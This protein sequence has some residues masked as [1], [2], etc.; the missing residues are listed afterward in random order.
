MTG[1]GLDMTQF[2]D[3]VGAH[4]V[5][6]QWWGHQVGWRSYRDEWLSEGFAEFTSGLVLE[7]RKGSAALNSFYELKRKRILEK[8]RGGRLTSDQA[9]PIIQGLRL[10]TL[11]TPG[12]YSVVV[13]DK[14]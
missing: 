12:A 11:Q 4:E 8:Q 6:H 5:A 2:V 7:M 1:F 10:S 3:Q 13:Y 9:G 14:G